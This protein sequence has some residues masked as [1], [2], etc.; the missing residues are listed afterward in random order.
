MCFVAV[1]F[2]CTEAW[3][4]W[5]DTQTWHMCVY[6]FVAQDAGLVSETAYSG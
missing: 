4:Y 3:V 2:V 5:M 1:G 6:A